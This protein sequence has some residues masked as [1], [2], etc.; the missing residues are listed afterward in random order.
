MGYGCYLCGTNKY[1]SIMK[2]KIVF[3]M[4]AVAAFVWSCSQKQEQQSIGD[5]ADAATEVDWPAL[6]EFHMTMAE[7]YH[8]YRDSGNV[9]PVVDRAEELAQG[10]ANWAEEPL[11]E[12]VDSDE[13]KNMLQN[14][15]AGTRALADEVAGGG[16]PEQIGAKLTEVH[17]LFHHIQEAWY[18]GGHGGHEGH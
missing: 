2:N 12:R 15:K 4:L 18:G 16:T 5:D 10:A 8:P 7:V 6:D 3:V 1:L 14:L 17:D 13:V 11:P 9:Q